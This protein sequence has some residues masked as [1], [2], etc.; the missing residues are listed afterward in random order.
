MRE[1]AAARWLVVASLA[2]CGA[3][4]AAESPIV[5]AE[6]RGAE[7]TLLTYPEWFLVH[8]PAEYAGW[9]AHEPAHGFP[10]LGHVAQ[11][12]GGYAAV[13]RE[14]V[15]MRAPA[16]GGYHAMILVIATSTTV[17]YALRSAYE[18]TIGRIAWATAS[19]AGTD[20]DRYGARVAQEYVDFIRREPWYLFDF[21]SRLRGLWSDVPLLGSNVVR[22]IERRYALTTEYAAKAAYAW[23]IERATRAAYDP[24]RPVT[25]VVADRAPPEPPEGVR[26]LATLPDGR[27]VLEL[28]RYYDFRLAATALAARGVRLV[29]V[30]G[31][32]GTILVTLWARDPVA[33][34]AGARV[35]FDQPLL[36][37]P[38]RR[39]VALLVPVGALSAFL[40]DAQRHGIAVEHVYDY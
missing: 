40:A 29:D 27:A 16:N 37:M 8:S 14:Q 4:V 17:E 18:N 23:L 5:P 3:P 19:R 36:T 13:T 1:A 31:N 10:F 22:K 26:V 32:D 28:P 15:R 34:P 35:L 25:H 7:H 39:R 11:L 9:V 2:F 33:M 6:R 12:W 20:E 24:A 38:G 30:A 21:A